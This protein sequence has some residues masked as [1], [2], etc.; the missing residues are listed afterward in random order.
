MGKRIAF[1]NLIWMACCALFGQNGPAAPPPPLEFEVA[2]VKP[3]K[4]SPDGFTMSE[5]LD[6]ALVRLNNMSMQNCI[7]RAF[8]INSYQLSGPD[9]MWSEYYDI[10]AKMPA[11][12]SKKRFPAM[13]QKLLEQ[14]F[15]L[16]F[17]R[18]PRVLP[19]YALLVSSGG[20]K[21]HPSENKQGA[22]TQVQ[23]GHIEAHETSLA[24]LAASLYGWVDR[25]VLDETGVPG[26]F[27][28]TLDWAVDEEHETAGLPSIRVALEEKLGLKLEP[29][30]LPVEMLVI[31]H[32]EKK[33]SE[34]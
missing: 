7:L 25:P 27:D 9:W 3:A 19:A 11:G 28:F 1:A 26:A 24:Y 6:P 5:N 16:K 34:N 33:P 4:V 8:G 22:G 29:R 17:H 15:Q 14:R 20:L 23:A 32:I 31:D 21:I 18:E 13:L 30:K 12:A 10:V 2:S